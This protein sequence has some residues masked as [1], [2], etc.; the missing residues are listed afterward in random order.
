[1]EQ[2]CSTNDLSGLNNMLC[3]VVELHA[4]PD[5][6]GFLPPTREL[7][8][9]HYGSVLNWRSSFHAPKLL[10]MWAGLFSETYRHILTRSC[11]TVRGQNTYSMWIKTRKQMNHSVFFLTWSICSWLGI[12]LW[13]AR[14]AIM[15]TNS[16]LL[17]DNVVLQ[18]FSPL[19]EA[20]H[21]GVTHIW[22]TFVVACW[23]R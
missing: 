13:G 4:D 7:S 6:I 11:R 12:F 19:D 22:L 5:F 17:K 20:L 8:E 23:D 1:M 16:S 9:S 21:F 15:T 2:V 3:P 10:K 18:S 14:I